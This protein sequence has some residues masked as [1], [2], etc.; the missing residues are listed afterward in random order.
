MSTE[1]SKAIIRRYVELLDRQDLAGLRG[2]AGPNFQ[3]QFAGTPGAMDLEGAL[4]LFGMFFAALPDVRHSVDTIVGEGD[5]VALRMTVRA[6]HQGEMMGIPANGKTVAF[7]SVNT[8]HIADGKVVG[9]WAVAD[10]LGMMQQIGAIP[11]P[12]RSG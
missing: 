12:G 7:Q 5:R 11:A 6:T 3:L 1:D 9:H 10:L 2:L 4:G 8:F